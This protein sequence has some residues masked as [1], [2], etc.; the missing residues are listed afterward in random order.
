MKNNKY[1]KYKKKKRDILLYIT[2]NTYMYICTYMKPVLIIYETETL[3][4]LSHN[5]T[6][7]K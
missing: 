7:I 1:K 5:G 6:Q 3:T 4:S 2:H